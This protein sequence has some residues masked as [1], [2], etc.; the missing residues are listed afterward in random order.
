[1]NRPPPPLLLSEPQTRDDHAAFAL[2]KRTCL[3]QAE[4][5]MTKGNNWFDMKAPDMTEEKKNDLLVLQYRNSLDP[6]RFYKALDLK[7]LPKYFQV[8]F[9]EHRQKSF[10]P[11]FVIHDGGTSFS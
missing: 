9:P 4:R 6:K 3:F 7:T 10:F 11:C 8:R 1:M 2:T 5:E